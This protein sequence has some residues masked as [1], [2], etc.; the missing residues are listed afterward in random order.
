[1]CSAEGEENII[2]ADVLID[3]EKD[4]NMEYATV[5][6]DGYDGIIEN[7]EGKIRPI[8]F[9]GQLINYDSFR[10]KVNGIEYM[11]RDK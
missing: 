10:E 4:N 5:I 3:N 7:Y 9:N 6:R 11:G 8:I 2:V 1:M